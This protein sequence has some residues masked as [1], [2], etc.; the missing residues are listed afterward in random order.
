MTTYTS[1][2]DIGYYA[3]PA[4]FP[5]ATIEAIIAKSL[6]DGAYIAA[7]SGADHPLAADHLRIVKAATGAL[8]IRQFPQLAGA[9]TDDA[10]GDTDA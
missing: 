2:T 7:N 6:A 8:L 5:E 9:L 4:V 3:D 10:D 1:P